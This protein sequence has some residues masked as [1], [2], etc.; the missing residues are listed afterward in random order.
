MRFGLYAGVSSALAAAAI[1]RACLERPNFYSSSVYIAQ[2]NACLFILT[3]LALLSTYSIM[4]GLQKAFYGPLRPVEIEQLWE[5]A[6][7]A[8]TETALAMTI[9]RD[10]VG[11][12]FLFMFTFLLIS[13]VWNWL[14]E[15]RV[16]ILE[17]QPPAN[18][19][20]FHTRLSA[21]LC[22]SVLFSV[23][24]LRFCASSVLQQARPNM[25]VMFAFEFAV[26]T[27]LSLSTTARYALSLYETAVIKRQITHGREQL[28]NRTE[29]PLSEEEANATDI[30][31]AGWEEKGQWVFYLDIATDF[32]KLVL[33]LTFFC[34]LCM[35][36]GMPI[37]IIRD[38]ALTI[39]SFYKR[40]RDF[41][42][43]KQATRDMNARYP[44]ATAEEIV[45]EDV[46][47]ICR[48]NM[49][50]WQNP[51]EDGASGE[52]RPIDERQRAKKLPCGHLLHFACLRSWLERQQICPTC[53]TPVLGPH[54]ESPN[55][56][57]RARPNARGAPGGNNP[58]PTG[59]HVYTFGP[60]RLV[61]GARQIN[62]NQLPHPAA[63]SAATTAGDAS[64]VVL[65]HR[66]PITF[67]SAAMSA[68]LNQ[69]EQQ[70]TRE[71]SQLSHLSDQLHV[72]RALQGELARLRGA[73][74][75][76]GHPGP[77]PPYQSRQPLL[78]QSMQ[79]YREVP[80]GSGQRNLPAGMTIP[81]GW[82]LHV[83][84]RIPGSAY[85]GPQTG[86]SEEALQ[87][88]QSAN[89]YSQTQANQNHGVPIDLGSSSHAAQ[90]SDAGVKQDTTQEV[91]LASSEAE[92]NQAEASV[93]QRGESSCAPPAWGSAN[94]RQSAADS[95]EPN[96]Q[97]KGKGKAVTVE[98]DADD[99]NA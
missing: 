86:A 80:V 78:Q 29:N 77:S 32:F 87:Q 62:N 19:R 42:Q 15:G 46:C 5:K 34:V 11:G 7:F 98:D 93:P 57:Q 73:Q 96:H 35:F 24:M 75:I 60:F 9:F 53:R 55:P 95:S 47:I 28:R 74:G 30:D 16:E 72:L 76:P 31:A 82:T 79:A 83:L 10:E 91:G 45:R 20:L 85:L 84:H 8:L 23:Y 68:Q 65:Q 61:V 63:A 49:T 14:A 54:V 4:L 92:G 99:A 81:E 17:Q 25:M 18:P 69:I 64:Q 50:V 40:I 1:A 13:K 38:V 90:A 66:H 22:L 37:H 58:P 43:Y 52:R 27:I 3:N 51:T 26:L 33:Y 44:D 12:W 36:Y 67:S 70:I 89:D 88:Q 39:R 94:G 59:P 41:V 6:W 71:M 21:A 56:H 2:S 48:E 97:N